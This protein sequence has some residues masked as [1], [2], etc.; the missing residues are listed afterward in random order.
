MVG[1]FI[2]II[3]FKRKKM[4]LYLL[5]HAKTDQFSES[6]KDFD[7]KLL[8]KGKRQ[9][10]V[11]ALYFKSKSFQ[12]SAIFCSSSARTR[13]TLSIIKKL[14][15]FD[16]EIKYVD[17]LYLCE[18]EFLLSF[19]CQQNHKEDIFIIGHNNGISD[20][21]GYLLNDFIDL[22]TSEFLCI[23]FQLD[24]WNEVSKGLGS[25]CDRFHPVV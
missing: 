3:Y 16:S 15:S 2:F 5:R 1:R 23:D 4:K 11:L 7:R 22:S 25:L 14:V 17:D 10:N 18:K 19:L 13:Q 20:F 8:E 21:A 12:P 6:G 9:A 24:S